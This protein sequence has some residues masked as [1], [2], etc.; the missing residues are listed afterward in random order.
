M[1]KKNQKEKL[2]NYFQKFNKK[3][4]VEGKVL[5]IFSGDDNLIL[6]L[7][8]SKQYLVSVYIFRKGTF[9]RISQERF[10]LLQEAK[11][12]FKEITVEF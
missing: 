9:N 12:R 10:K 11:N 6:E 4:R 8:K 3:R 1:S 2:L 5:A 7:R